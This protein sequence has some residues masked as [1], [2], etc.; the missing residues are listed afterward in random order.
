MTSSPLINVIIPTRERADVLR[1]T[2]ATVTM[3]DYANL[4]ILVSDNASTDDTATVVER[5]A[6]PRI[7]YLNTGRRLSM[8]HNWEFALNAVEDGWVVV[9]GDDDGLLPG[10]IAELARLIE[11]TGSLAIRSR[12]CTYDW[13]SVHGNLHGELIVPLGAGVE[14]RNSAEWLEKVLSGWRKYTEL[15][16]VYD[17]GAIHIAL[18][19]RI[20]D[21]LG[22]FFQ[23]SSPDVS[24]A[25]AVASVVESYAFS[26]RPF[27]IAG[28]SRHSIGTSH[29]ATDKRRDE[30]PARRFATEGNPPFHPE[31]PLHEDGGYPLSLHALFYEAWLHASPLRPLAPPTD[32]ER[33]LEVILASSGK[34]RSSIDAWSRLFAAQHG[35]DY[36]KAYAAAARL[37]PRFEVWQQARKTW[38]AV[39]SVI[40]DRM[41]VRNILEA[42]IAAGTILASPGRADTARFFGRSLRKVFSVSRE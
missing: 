39:N 24:S 32:H 2:L 8:T 31:M 27:V 18:F 12:M 26:R 13:P 19:R 4:R 25:A 5:A 38:T 40:S 23:A 29:F 17:G 9:I 14:E 1:S 41:P 37:R 34:H 15:P 10:G 30:S 33:Q 16:M 42:S 36:E 35:L 22:S 7:V 11:R 6:D 28:T 21:T 20:R 3:Q